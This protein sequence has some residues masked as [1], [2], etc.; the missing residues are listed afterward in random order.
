MPEGDAQLI[1][2]RANVSNPGGSWSETDYDVFDGDRDVGRV[3][4]V[5]DQPEVWF[6]GVSFQRA[7]RATVMRRRSMTP[8]RRSRP[9]MR[10]GRQPPSADGG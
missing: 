2:R 4:R 6:W 3:Y 10:H 9:S 1:L 8:R 5:D 7:A